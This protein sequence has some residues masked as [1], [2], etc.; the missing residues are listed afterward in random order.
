MLVGVVGFIGSGKG[1]VGDI[2]TEFGFNKISFASGVKDLAAEMFGWDRSL[3]EG[4][5]DASR[6]FR[7]ELDPFW[8][9][10]LGKDFTPRLALQLLGTEVGRGIFHEDFWVI[11]TK[12]EIRKIGKDKNFVVTDVRFPNEIKMI[13]ENHGIIIEV[14]RGHNPHWRDIAYQANHGE[15]HAETFMRERVKVHES[16]WRWIGSDIDRTISN[17]GTKDELKKKIV[18]CLTQF[19]GSSIIENI[20]NNKELC[21]ETV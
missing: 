13:R 15:H 20:M 12:N 14:S 2:L 17:D 10:E 21:D 11:K 6:K 4:D 3:L 7:E 18:E 8:T 19:Y 16:E 9:K 5:T 1:T